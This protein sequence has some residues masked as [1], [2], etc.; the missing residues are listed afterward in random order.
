MK[1][2]VDHSATT[3]LFP[4]VIQVMSRF[5]AKNFGNPSSLHSFGL[6]A[7]RALETARENVAGL[8][9]AQSDE[10]FFTSG[11]TE[12][13]N[14]AI[15]GTA[16]RF[17]EGG[18]MITTQIE[19]P[20][21][22][23]P[24]R[25]LQAHGFDVTF[26]EPDAEGFIASKKLEKALRRDTRLVSIMQANNEVGTVLPVTKMGGI[27]KDAGALFHVDAVQAAGK[28]PVNV[29]EIPADFL[30]CSSHK[31]N[32]PKGV[33]AL[34][35]R[36]GSRLD[37]RIYGGGQE[38][39]LR[40]GTENLPGIVGFGEAAKITAEIWPQHMAEIK[41]LR[42][43]LWQMLQENIPGIELN[44]HPTKRLPH[45]LH[46]SIP[47]IEG[48]AF[49]LRLDMSGIAVSSGSACSSASH[50]P[51]HVLKA[52]QLSPERLQ[53]AVRITLGYGNDMEQMHYIAEHMT[54]ASQTLLAMSPFNK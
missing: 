15:L 52:M 32:G 54:E 11:G 42:D 37:R 22:L 53:C 51:S 1:V 19:H 9:G 29:Q 10:I 49:L 3:P 5:L 43:T 41:N 14:L 13:D 39:Q 8:I 30:T 47:H 40:S 34:F 48:E 45:N 38:R 16:A 50:E 21:V 26:L 2:Y 17:P 25:Y 44:G 31:I 46:V 36:Q 24:F 20:A 35:C 28:I 18:H 7:R 27:A 4:E 12:A 6:D 33:G 23:E